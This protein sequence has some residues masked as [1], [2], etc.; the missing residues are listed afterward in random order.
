MVK[1]RY[2]SSAV[3][4]FL[5]FSTQAFANIITDVEAVNS[6]VGYAFERGNSVSWTHDLSDQP[7]F[8]GTASSATLTV[9]FSDD[10]DQPWNFV[11]EFAQIVV[12]IIDFQDDDLV[13]RP[14]NDW[15]TS[16]SITSLVSLNINGLLDV[17][18]SSIIGDFL[19][20]NSVLKVTT[21]SFG[22]LGFKSVPEPSTLVLMGLGLV[23]LCLP[24]MRKA[25]L[26]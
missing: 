5:L 8:P 24:R 11:P 2:F 21:T 3:F 14:V 26:T 1:L 16:L 10:Y 25:K 12:G 19:V 23:G 9:E 20:G 22:G 7:F 6:R 18:V 15:G 4:V 17:T 13:F